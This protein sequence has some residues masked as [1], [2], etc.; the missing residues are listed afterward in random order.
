MTPLSSADDARHN[1]VV[2]KWCVS[3]LEAWSEL[4]YPGVTG[5][6]RFRIYGGNL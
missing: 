6:M 1:R 2:F 5:L 3:L 4:K